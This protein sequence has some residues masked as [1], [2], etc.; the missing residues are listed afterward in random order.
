MLIVRKEDD[1]PT[2]NA[3]KLPVI[4]KH[5]RQTHMIKTR[6]VVRRD[7]E[8]A[9]VVKDDRGGSERPLPIGNKTVETGRHDVS[10]DYRLFTTVAR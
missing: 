7:A 9:E 10:Y 4:D 5:C 6:D 2:K 3:R 8:E 1:N